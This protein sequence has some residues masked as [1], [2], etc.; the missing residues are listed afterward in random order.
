[1]GEQ[2]TT[3]DFNS[4]KRQTAILSE[5]LRWVSSNDVK[6]STKPDKFYTRCWLH[7][8]ETASMCINKDTNT[9]HCFGCGA[10]GTVL[11]I[12]IHFM[13]LNPKS[14]V[15][16][17]KA[18]KAILEDA[19]TPVQMPAE[20]DKLKVNKSNFQEAKKRYYKADAQMIMRSHEQLLKGNSL[21]YDFGMERG[22]I[23]PENP[24]PIGIGYSYGPS[25]NEKVLEFPKLIQTEQTAV[26]FGLEKQWK[27]WNGKLA[28]DMKK[29]LTPKAERLWEAAISSGKV[30]PHI[31]KAPRWTAIPEYHDWIPWEFDGRTSQTAKVLCITEGPGD[32]IR[33]EN[34]LIRNGVEYNFHVTAI[35]S[36]STLKSQNFTRVIKEGK[37]NSF[38]DGFEEICFFFDKDNAGNLCKEAAIDLLSDLRPKG[39]V[40]FM[41]LPDIAEGVKDIND[42]F[43]NE[44]CVNDLL[45]AY[46]KTDALTF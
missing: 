36:A 27:E 38:F 15:D 45:D 17:V 34:E 13:G 16:V 20:F 14:G 2:K 41:N 32:G 8:E 22:W 44:G 3:I 25:Y 39:K 46:E 1:M 28:L 42:Y 24:Y 43:D 9:Y 29:R 40:R 35:D 6:R 37:A 30:S 33:L 18:A 4:L 12:R 26:A 23:L 19:G 7:S 5:L 10:S 31:R 21:A 11:D